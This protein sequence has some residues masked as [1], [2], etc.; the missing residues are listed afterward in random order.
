LTTAQYRHSR[1]H[2]IG[3][4]DSFDKPARVVRAKAE[5]VLD[6]L[7]EKETINIRH[8][9]VTP[10]LA[11]NELSVAE[12]FAGGG[13]MATGLARA[14]YSLSWA[15]D[16]DKNAVAAY[17]YNLG[18]H[19]IQGDIITIDFDSIP[20]TDVI[21]GGPPC[22]D[23]SV[24]GSGAGE[25]GERGKLVW[26]YLALIERKKPRAFIFEN[27][28]GLV[29]KRHRPTFD[30]LLTKFDEIGYEVSWR[31]VNAWDY[32]VAQKRERVFIVGIRKDLGFTF[33]FPEPDAALY[34][35]QVIRDAIG[36]LPEPTSYYYNHPRNYGKKAVFNVDE[37]SPTIKT[38]NSRPMPSN[39][40][41]HP[42]DANV[43]NHVQTRATTVKPEHLLSN[44]RGYV[45]DMDGAGRTV[46]VCRLDHAEIHPTQPRRFTV[47]ECLR[48]QSVPDSYVLPDSI[49]LSAQYRIVGNGVASRVAYLLGIALAQQLRKVVEQ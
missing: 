14:G 13:L 19:V 38:H 27:V 28:K 9:D 30:A 35:T 16:F 22:Q 21:A 12:V 39:Y 23:F 2:L 31:I 49:S 7:N 8:Y 3:Y 44:Q 46:N 29:S 11:N 15:N 41:P 45:A 34:R 36:D 1:D 18:D 20:D 32:G 4:N 37:P 43:Q 47:R 6:T 5:N 17:R 40:T 24:A 48:I 25:D 33:E 42:N 26:T 10:Q